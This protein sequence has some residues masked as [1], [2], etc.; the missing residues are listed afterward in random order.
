MKT[1]KILILTDDAKTLEESPKSNTLFDIYSGSF[2][3]VKSFYKKLK[4]KNLEVDLKILL[5]SNLIGDAFDDLKNSS[6][7]TVSKFLSGINR[8]TAI[9][10]LLP[11][12]RLLPFISEYKKSNVG[13]K[14]Y[15]FIVAPDSIRNEIN[16]IFSKTKRMYFFERVGVARLTKNYSNN[17][18]QA[19]LTLKEDG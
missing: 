7:V 8:Y 12:N 10:I 3:T 9:V 13:F 18:I 1:P 2:N 14:G 17:I 6:H 16:R 5:G 4:E 11:K 19:L 15:V